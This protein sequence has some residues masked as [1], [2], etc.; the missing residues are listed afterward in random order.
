MNPYKELIDTDI[1]GKNI[2]LREDLNVPSKNSEIVNDERIRAAIP[3]INYILSKNA[4]VSII[5]HFGRPNEG[6][7][8]EKY[9]L[10]IGTE[11]FILK[12]FH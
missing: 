11:A 9:S 4:K 6:K 1:Q 10:R 3:T 5:S 12:K 8:D 7:F 2:L